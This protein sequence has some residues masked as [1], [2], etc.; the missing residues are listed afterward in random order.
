MKTR[1]YLKFSAP[2]L[3]A[4]ALSTAAN[5]APSIT[6]SIGFGPAPLSGVTLQ[7]GLGNTTTS[8]AA[9][10]GVKAWGTTQVTT[11]GGSFATFVAGTNTPAFSAP[12]V[13]NPSTPLPAL[14]TITGSLAGGETFTFNLTSS[15]IVTQN[16]SFLNVTGTGTMTGTGTTAYAATAGTF[17][18][19]IPSP[20]AGEQFTWTSSSAPVPDGGTTMALLG[21]SLL[22]LYGA[23]RKFAT[24]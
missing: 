17:N 22:G 4:L 13:F 15:S 14:W 16:A 21:V 23:R 7:D 3:V 5:A 1:S 9:A 2:L 8:L 11:V 18:F 10:K 20:G 12:W 19:T 6:G 24:A